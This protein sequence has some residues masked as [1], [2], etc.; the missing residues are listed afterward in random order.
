MLRRLHGSALLTVLAAT[1]LV[2]QNQ[3]SAPRAI[4]L[5]D[6]LGANF[7]VSDTLTG[8]SD[9]TDYDFLLGTW[10]FRFQARRRDGGFTAPFTG[11]WVF[12]KKQTG[13]EGVL[14]EDHWRPDEAS[15]TWEAGT[16]TYRAFNP[17]R[18]LWE[19]QG[20]N[21]NAG[22]WQSGLMW[23]A[24]D[25]RLLIEW[26]GPMLVRFRYFAVE[27]DKFLWRAD[28][29]FDRGKTWIRDY[30]TMEVHRISR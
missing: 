14:I 22:A 3:G 24:G 18:K 26:Y 20:I 9:P 15:S 13:G 2:A 19:M 6:T 4:V 28:A 17:E 7:S 21:T 30:W 23:R 1:P 5:P 27:A 16:W 11:H 25:D 29:T 10:S 8:K 12:S